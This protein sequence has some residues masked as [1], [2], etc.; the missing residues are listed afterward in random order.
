MLRVA[1][2]GAVGAS[3]LTVGF[4]LLPGAA[5]AADTLGPA[6]DARVGFI[7]VGPAGM[8]IEG[9]TQE[10][11]VVSGESGFVVT[12][13]LGNLT[14]GIALRDRHMKEKYLE[15]PK[16]RETTLTVARPQLKIPAK[17]ETVQG[18]VQG[19]LNLHGQ[20]KPV[21]FHYEAR[22][23]GAQMVVNGR[24]HILMTDYGISVP[25]Y[26]GVTVK[27]D[28]DVTASFKVAGGAS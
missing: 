19:T 9:T 10:L 13:P 23:D 22:G 4:Y 7:A 25:S 24:M 8:R 28:V 3:L 15:V 16:F 18:D 27:P 20:S 17:G 21:T 11:K 1:T 2:A 6:S 5:S 26:L 14:T 12:V